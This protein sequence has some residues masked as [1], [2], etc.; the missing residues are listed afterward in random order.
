MDHNEKNS[1]LT[2]KGSRCDQQTPTWLHAADTVAASVE[3]YKS[4]ADLTNAALASAN[5]AF[6][7]KQ[8]VS[9]L[10]QIFSDLDFP[11]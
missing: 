4:V 3:P 10:Q 2:K 9:A 8:Y 6:G 11:S 5:D 1:P 7:V